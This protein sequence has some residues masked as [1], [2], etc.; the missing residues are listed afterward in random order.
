[1][2]FAIL[3]ERV[4]HR[5]GRFIAIGLEGT[6]HHSPAAVRH[7]CALQRR[8]R[9]KSDN[10]LV[11]LVDLAR[12]VRDDRAR[13]Q[14]NVE[15]AFLA[16]LDEHVCQFFPD[17][18]GSFLTALISLALDAVDVSLRAGLNVGSV[19]LIGVDVHR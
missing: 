1:M 14:R 4:H 2:R 6:Q 12:R 3:R 17:P 15:H 19:S 11:L 8:V 9:P 5:L 18:L 13:D 7:D 16:F 10:D